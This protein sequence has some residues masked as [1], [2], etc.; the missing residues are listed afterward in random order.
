MKLL[1]LVLLAA[2]AVWLPATARADPADNLAP[3]FQKCG[4][5]EDKTCAAALW[6]FADVTGDGRLTLAELTRFFRIAAQVMA[7]PEQPQAG[8]QTP[9]GPGGA[10]ADDNVAYA[11]GSAFLTGPIAANLVIA[12]FDYDDDG[13]ISKSELFLDLD[14][15]EFRQLMIEEAAKLPQRAGG[16]MMRALQAQ[17]ELGGG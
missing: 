9:S 3:I 14:E 11:V 17:Q 5:V 16:L 4:Q 8:A 13:V 6:S 1:T 2:V 7:R 12:N 15:E 10:M